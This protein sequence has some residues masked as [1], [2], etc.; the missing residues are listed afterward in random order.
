MKKNGLESLDES[1]CYKLYS[2]M[3]E[4]TFILQEGN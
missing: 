1:K 4:E 3:L 2:F